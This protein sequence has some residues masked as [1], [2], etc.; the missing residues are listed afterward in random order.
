MIMPGQIV[1][2]VMA[3][4]DTKRAEPPHRGLH[5]PRSVRRIGKDLLRRTFSEHHSYGKETAKKAGDYA[6]DLA[7]QML[8][9]TLG[10]E[11]DAGEGVER[12]RAGVPRRGRRSLKTRSIVQSAEGSPQGAVDDGDCVRS[13][14]LLSA[15]SG[16]GPSTRPGSSLTYSLPSSGSTTSRVGRSR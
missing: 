11:F 1:H 6:E 4:Q 10:V 12:A 7:A 13:V 3:R 14:H 2:C 8:A 5:R 9:T 16:T 15:G